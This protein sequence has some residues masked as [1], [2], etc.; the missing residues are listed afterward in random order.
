VVRG[1][2]SIGI[3][4]GES[5]AA[6]RVGLSWGRGRGRKLA[7]EA[8]TGGYWRAESVAPQPKGIWLFIRSIGSLRVIRVSKCWDWVGVTA[9]ESVAKPRRTAENRGERLLQL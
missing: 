3:A 5:G 8:R 2:W 9:S 1:P 4:R 6:N 7:D